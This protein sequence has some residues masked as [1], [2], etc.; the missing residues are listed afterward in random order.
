MT[1]EQLE[2]IRKFVSEFPK[3][4]EP[5]CPETTEEWFESLFLGIQENLGIE[6]DD[7]LNEA[8]CETINNQ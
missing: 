1:N 7:E 8:V 3:N 2:Q 5:N 4:E 6:W